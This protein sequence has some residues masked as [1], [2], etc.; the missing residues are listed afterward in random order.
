MDRDKQIGLVLV[1]DL[2]A[3]EQRDKLI[4]LPGQ[5]GFNVLVLMQKTP[6]MVGNFQH[7]VFFL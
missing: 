6:H 3:L 7:H 5:A 2:H 1:G 4:L